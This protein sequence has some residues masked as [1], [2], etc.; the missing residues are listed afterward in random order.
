MR[1]RINSPHYF[2]TN[3]NIPLPTDSPHS[4]YDTLFQPN[5]IPYKNQPPL[6]EKYSPIEKRE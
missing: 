5:D 3:F 1:S 6:Q 2:S 4:I